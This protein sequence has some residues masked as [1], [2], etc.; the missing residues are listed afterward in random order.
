M[1]EECSIE[2]LSSRLII[3]NLPLVKA[4]V[5]SG[6]YHHH[7]IGDGT[8]IVLSWGIHDE[9]I[10]EL[11]RRSLTNF[12]ADS[13]ASR[14]LASQE[15]LTNGLFIS[16][17]VGIQA[18][19]RL[20][21]LKNAHPQSPAVQF[22]EGRPVTGDPSE[23]GWLTAIPKDRKEV[24]FVDGNFYLPVKEIGYAVQDPKKIPGGD[25]YFSVREDGRMDLFIRR[26][27]RE[28]GPVGWMWVLINPFRS[29]PE[30]VEAAIDPLENYSALRG[31]S[32]GYTPLFWRISRAHA[33]ARGWE[34]P[35]DGLYSDAVRFCI[36]GPKPAEAE[37]VP[38]SPFTDFEE[39][40]LNCS[41]E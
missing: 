15:P 1:V 16:W 36:H 13:V 37:F 10:A 38:R 35:R 5:E 32:A 2:D 27:S 28:T 39:Y 3:E 29:A 21:D 19:G 12:T 11:V 33:R 30:A 8:A 23:W 31:M 18:R 41:V 7:E 14:W 17:L 20:E 4:A 40:F 24:R 9:M 6:K 34:L 25:G 22:L 26:G